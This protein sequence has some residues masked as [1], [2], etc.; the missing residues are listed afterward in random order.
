MR[1]NTR[2]NTSIRELVDRP[3]VVPALILSIALLL[4]LAIIGYGLGHR[5]A[6]NVISVTGSASESVT[7]DTAS[8]TI[9]LNRTAPP[10]GITSAYGALAKDSASVSAFLK[11]QKL[12]SSTVTQGVVSSSPN[13]NSN[14][15][16]PTTYT[17][18]ERVTVN[19]TDVQKIDA[20]SHDLSS[21]QNGISSDTI[22]SPEPPAY[23]ISTLPNLRVT[24][25][26]KA[27]ED[28]K[29]RAKEIAKSGGSSVG[30]LNSASSGVVQITAP[31]ST[32]ADD[33]GSY[34]TSTIQKVV[35][36]TAHVS[37]YVK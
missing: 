11:A 12:A 9:D 7:A 28:A 20:L 24:L 1:Y 32:S 37:F 36:V 8:W 30:A 4:G 23:Y 6:S 18:T 31:N 26:G 29:A 2:M 25:V 15:G 35:M 22:L 10:E 33:Y 17:V 27:V 21:L 16:T 5:N 34:D 14:G 13:Y 3:F 19:T